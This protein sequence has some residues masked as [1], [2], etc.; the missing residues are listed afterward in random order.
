M[1]SI[2][3]TKKFANELSNWY[4]ENKRDLPFRKTSDPYKIFVSELMLQQTQVDTVIPYYL[5]FIER[6]PDVYA[7][8]SAPVD[9]VLKLWE[10]LGYYRR[11]RYIYDTAQMIVDEYQGVFP[12][13]LKDIESLKGV[14]RYTARAIHSIAFNQPSAAVDGNVMRV[15]SRVMLYE[16]DIAKTKH[17]KEIESYVNNLIIHEVPSDFTQAMMEL[18]ATICTKNP[19]CEICPVNKYCFAYKQKEQNNYP[20]KSKLKAKTHEHFMVMIVRFTDQYLMIQRPKHGL[21]A[22]MYEFP[23]FNTKDLSEAKALFNEQFNTKIVDETKVFS[24]EHVFTHKVWHL[25]IYEVSLESYEGLPLIS[26]DNF[27]YAISKAHLKII[28]LIK[29]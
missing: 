14:G 3:Y 19:R 5:K 8:A 22:N 12:N 11:A 25:S 23:Q 10:G 7:L 18:G 20:K 26:L 9:E 15:M 13:Q 16:K 29:K 1:K 2:Q 6:F 4:R 28:D 17:M 21:L 27:P 24:I